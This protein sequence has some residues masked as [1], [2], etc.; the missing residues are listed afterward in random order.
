M[1]RLLYYYFCPHCNAYLI[2]PLLCELVGYHDLLYVLTNYSWTN[3]NEIHHSTLRVIVLD[4]KL[5]ISDL[6]KD[7]Y[8]KIGYPISLYIFH[9]IGCSFVVEIGCYPMSDSIRS[10]NMFCIEIGYPI[11][12]A[13]YCLIGWIYGIEISFGCSVELC[14]PST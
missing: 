1:Y 3:S 12:T 8:L 2:W 4:L 6:Y 10:L 9:P 14:C 5:F 11:S 7:F 13:I